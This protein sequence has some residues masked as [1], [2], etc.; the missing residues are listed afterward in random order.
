MGNREGDAMPRLRFTLRR[1]MVAVAISGLLLGGA[2]SLQNR[3]QRFLERARAINMSNH[4]GVP[5]VIG[6]D[7][8]RD[9][10][11]LGWDRQEREDAH[12]AA[13]KRKYEYAARYPWLP[14]APDP[15][16]PRDGP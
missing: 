1:M 10:I 8:K 15:T 6:Y 16:E 12:I 9:L 3:R 2:T 14:V 5:P 4:L 13:L 11:L 7:K